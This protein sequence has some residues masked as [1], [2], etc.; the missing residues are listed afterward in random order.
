MLSVLLSL[1]A[2][3]MGVWLIGARRIAARARKRSGV[4]VRGHAHIDDRKRLLAW[5]RDSGCG[6]VGGYDAKRGLDRL[7]QAPVRVAKERQSAEAATVRGLQKLPAAVKFK[8]DP[9]LC[10]RLRRRGG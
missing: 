1:L 9:P 4:L 3:F 10:L 2:I 7:F 8:T 5:R 6:R